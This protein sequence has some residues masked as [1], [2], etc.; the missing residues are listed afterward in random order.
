MAAWSYSA[1]TSFELCPKK[2][3]HEN[4]KR[5]FRQS[6]SS[7]G[8]YGLEAHKKFEMRLIN[9][10]P[11]PLDLRHHEPVLKKLA[12]IPGEGM[13]EQKI[14]LTKDFQPT[15]FFDSDVWCRGVID[16]AK[17][18]GNKLIIVDHKFGKMKE[19]FDQLDLMFALMSAHL[20][21]IKHAVGMFYWAKDKQFTRKIYS[22]E[23]HVTE[24]W[25][26]FLPRVERLEVARKTTDFP[27][28]QNGLCRRYCPVK[29]CPFNG[30]Q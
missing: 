1:L 11:L 26:N 24:I 5:D 10:K 25:D 3:Y 30:D 9:G 2:Y 16:Y 27:A 4:I 22:T 29:T 23:P 8:D 28:R 17:V 19:G 21:E 13:P 20:P 14:A 18:T 15:G 7:I 12:D 6:R